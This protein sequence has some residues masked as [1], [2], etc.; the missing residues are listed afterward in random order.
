MIATLIERYT[1]ILTFNLPPALGYLTVYAF[2]SVF[3]QFNSRMPTKEI[4]LLNLL[5]CSCL[6]MVVPHSGYY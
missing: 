6:V 3:L 4:Q 1:W 5:L 2:V